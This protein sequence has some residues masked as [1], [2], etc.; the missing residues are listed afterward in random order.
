M[1][2]VEIRGIGGGEPGKS[3]VMCTV[4]RT[5]ERVTVWS[6]SK[7]PGIE[8]RLFNMKGR[9]FHGEIVLNKTVNCFKK[10]CLKSLSDHV[11]KVRKRERCI[12]KTLVSFV[13][14][15]RNYV[16]NKS[17]WMQ[18]AKFYDTLLL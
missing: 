1:G 14:N 3:R 11:Y 5:M 8:W 4:K 18:M 12:N 17:R 10:I 16:D 13:D 6:A 2:V 7:H 15:T 9:N